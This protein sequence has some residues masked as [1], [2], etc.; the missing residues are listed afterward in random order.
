MPRRTWR[1]LLG[2]LIE[3]TQERERLAHELG[4]H[5][6]T[7]WRWTSNKSKPRARYLKKLPEIFPSHQRELL[8]LL[9]KEYP[10]LFPKEEEAEKE[11]LHHIPSF[12]YA[13]VLSTL[14]DPGPYYGQ[15]SIFYHILNYIGA[16]LAMSGETSV[17][18]MVLSPSRRSLYSLASMTYGGG[19]F[20]VI[21]AFHM[22]I[23]RIIFAGRESLG[24]AVTTASIKMTG[25]TL[26]FP[27][28]RRSRISGCL[29][30]IHSERE[31][32]SPPKVELLSR[33]AD[34]L[35]IGFTDAQFYDPAQ[36]DL[37]TI[38]DLETQRQLFASYQSQYLSSLQSIS[39]LEDI[40]LHHSK[41]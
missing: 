41:P 15:E 1:D 9:R 13:R 18:V 34:L 36:V 38:P 11:A 21:L 23:D 4:V 22:M 24:S 17:L 3:D 2:E 20:P 10:D 30:V 28:R 33:Y 8:Q 40:L 12:D 26:A 39:E 37:A 31:A 35:A 25:S 7:P 29:W 6:W 16:Q 19:R 14:A 32:L 5:E 27:L